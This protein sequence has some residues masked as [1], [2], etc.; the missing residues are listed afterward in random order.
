MYMLYHDYRP[1]ATCITPQQETLQREFRLVKLKHQ[2]SIMWSHEY[3]GDI[4]LTPLFCAC[5][6]ACTL[7][8]AAG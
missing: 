3:N 2:N 1:A 6:L 4:N 5:H 7:S 8:C